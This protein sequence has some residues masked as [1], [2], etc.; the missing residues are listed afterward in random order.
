MHVSG[1]SLCASA[2]SRLARIGLTFVVGLIVPSVVSAQTDYYNT[3]AGRPVRIE[4]AYATERY[5]FELQLA[6]LRLERSPRGIYTWGVEPEIAYGILPRTHIEIGFPYAFIDAN[7]GGRTSGLTGLDVSL[8]H[9]LNI[10]TA[11]FPAFAVVG[12]ILAPVG[13]LAPDRAYG[14]V[15]GIV[16]RTYR[17]AR[18]HVNGQY[19]FGSSPPAT[20]ASGTS[21]LSRWLTGVA[22]DRTFPLRTLLVTGEVYASQP[23]HADDAVE[24]NAGIGLRYQLDPFFAVD[25]GAGRR[26]TGDDQAWYVTF[27]LARAFAIRSL[28]PRR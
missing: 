24:W 3:D 6:P 21:E 8:L 26:L 22:I 11:T 4:D 28:M 10:E 27:G 2:V 25:V 1:E 17:W 7:S 18:F 12:E 14:S 16:T 13:G 19:T 9:N 20:S 23:I 5:A 15:K